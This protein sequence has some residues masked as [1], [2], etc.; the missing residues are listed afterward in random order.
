MRLRLV[1][2]A[3]V[4]A[5]AVS[6]FPALALTADR[7]VLPAVLAALAFLALEL[8]AHLG[9][10]SRRRAAVS[11]ALAS[12]CWLVIA[13]AQFAD[14]GYA[15]SWAVLFGLAAGFAAFGSYYGIQ[16]AAESRTSAGI[17]LRFPNSCGC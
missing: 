17:P 7:V 13:L 2:L 12:S 15:W 3:G 9:R 8:V 16:R 10:A 11:G 4:V 1:A 14:V 5:L 6:A